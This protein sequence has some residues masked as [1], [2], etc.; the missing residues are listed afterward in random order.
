MIQWSR[1]ITGTSYAVQKF[2]RELRNSV[3]MELLANG[4][5]HG[6]RILC[7]RQ[8]RAVANYV[9]R[10]VEHAAREDVFT[11][12]V[13]GC[14]FDNGTQRTHIELSSDPDPYTGD[15]THQRRVV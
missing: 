15:S 9:N 4:A 12:K 14:V 5:D 10:F 7:E 8:T 3:R 13:S 2:A 11:G 1:T 6:D